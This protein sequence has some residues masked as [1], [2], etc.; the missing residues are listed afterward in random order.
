MSIINLTFYENLNV[1]INKLKLKNII[2]N[3]ID[4]WEILKDYH[5]IYN[6]LWIAENQ[7]LSCGPMGTL[8]KIYP[9]IFKPIINLFG[10]SRSF[11]IIYNKKEYNNNIKD[12]LFWMEYLNGIQYCIDLIILDG[13]IKFYSCLKSV[14]YNEGT[15]NYHES[16]PDYELPNNIVNWIN[17]NLSNYT[18]CV[19]LELINNNIIEAHLR[20]NG[21][22]YL[23]NDKFVIELSNLYNLK[24]WN[25][26][27]N[28]SKKYLIPI[29]VNKDI[30]LKLIDK[31]DIYLILKKYNCNNLLFDN[32]NSFYQKE[33]LSRYIMFENIDL[34]EGLKAKEDINELIFLS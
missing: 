27:Y 5:N 10:M 6:K 8:P 24:K 33:T 3:D 11:K 4:A 34:I 2:T 14:P 12:G 30:N 19:N 1:K 29:F 18:G 16:I 13:N 21:D 31:N 25:Y 28:I 7:N 15:F 22:F 26:E 23:Y 20:L 32:I 17:N 9:V